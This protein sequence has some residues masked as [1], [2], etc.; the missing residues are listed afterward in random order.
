M[1]LSK[2]IVITT[3]NKPNKAIELYSKWKGWKLIIVGDRKTPKWEDENII[4]L[5]IDQQ[6]EKYREL[7]KLVG[8]NTYKRKIFGYI[9]AIQHGAEM[10][11]ETDDDNFPYSWVNIY[12]KFGAS[13]CWPRGYPLEMIGVDQFLVNGDPDV[14]AVYRM[15]NKQKPITFSQQNPILLNPGEH[16]PF[17]TQA[18]LWQKEFFPLMF[19][20]LG[21]T[22]RTVDIVRSF[23]VLECLWRLGKTIAFHSPIMYQERN[24]HNLLKDFTQENPL[25]L[26]ANEWCKELTNIKGDTME[27]MFISGLEILKLDTHSYKLFISLL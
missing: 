16:C 26:H 10:I 3:I 23:I 14:D 17:N 4:F 18:T 2:F 9:Y 11:F 22:E 19:L 13:D 7:S 25:Y 8:E 20:P 27:E 6:H 1:K 24:T 5:D 15:T 12:E 21:T